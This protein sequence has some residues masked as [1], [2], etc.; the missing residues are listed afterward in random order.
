MKK[1]LKKLSVMRLEERVLFDAAAAAAAAEA[2]NQAQQNEELQQQQQQLQEQLAE[3]AAK[4]QAQQQAQTNQLFHP[5]LPVVFL[6][7]TTPTKYCKY[8]SG[9]KL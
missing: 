5:Y 6:H 2:E 3:E 9:G 8:R 4:Q 1:L 7:Y